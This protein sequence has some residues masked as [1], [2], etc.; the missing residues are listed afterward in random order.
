VV[1]NINDDKPVIAWIWNSPTSAHVV[2]IV[3]YRDP[4]TMLVFDPLRGPVEVAYDSFA[5]NWGPQHNWNITWVFSSNRAESDSS[6]QWRTITEP[7]THPAHPQGD[8]F[9]CAHGP[10]HPNGDIGPCGH[11]CHDQFG[12]T[13]PCHQG[14]IYPCAHPIHPAGHLVSC[15][16]LLHPGGHQRRLPAR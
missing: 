14:D 8:H 9:V 16:H 3:G 11:V 12:R 13:F 6:Q 1:S 7:C 4:R 5:A 10:M 15:S 2:V